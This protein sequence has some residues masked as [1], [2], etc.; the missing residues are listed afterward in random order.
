M[1]YSIIR[2]SQFKKSFKLAIKRGKNPEVFAKALDLLATNGRL[3]KEYLPH[4]LK[5]TY[6]GYW[7]CHLEPDWL[8]LWK[9]NDK[10]LILLLTDTGS[11]SDIFKK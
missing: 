5:G 1:K 10:E 4:M 7:E 11:H 2:T 9:Q 3:P 6:K 8:L